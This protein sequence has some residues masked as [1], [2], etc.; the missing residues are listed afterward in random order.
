MASPKEF[1]RFYDKHVD[2]VYRFLFFRVQQDKAIA[3]DLTSEVFLS[4]LQAFERFDQDRNEKA[5]IMTIA[6]NRVINYW[7]DKKD[8][9]DVDEIAFMLEGT[10]G[11]KEALVREDTALLRKAMSK[12]PA[13]DRRAVEMK[14]LLGYGHDDIARELGK[15]AGATRIAVH[16]AMKK[17]KDILGKREE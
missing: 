12:L 17:L 4:A 5:W 7:R 13:Q 3:E 11:R 10:D 1:G 6:R 15:S 2:S 16:R 14:Y 8:T 9:V